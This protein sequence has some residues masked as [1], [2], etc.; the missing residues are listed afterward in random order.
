MK[1]HGANMIKPAFIAILVF[2]WLSLSV[3]QAQTL[4]KEYVYNGSKLIATESPVPHVDSLS[5]TASSGFSTVVTVNLSDH[6]SFSNLAVVN[7]LINNYLNGNYA[8]Y[9][10]VV[11]SV[12]NWIAYLVND[13][14]TGYSSITI[15]GT[16]NTNNSQCTL[17]ASQSSVVGSGTQLTVKLA[18]TFSSGFVGGKVVYAAV[19]NVGGINSGWQP[20]GTFFVGTPPFNVSPQS[21][22]GSSGIFT[23]TFAKNGYFSDHTVVANILLNSALDGANACYM[24]FLFDQGGRTLILVNDPGNG[25]QPG[26]VGFPPGGGIGSNN[27]TQ[28]AANSQCSIDAS[29]S[30]YSLI[31]SSGNSVM[32]LTLK[33]NFFGAAFRGDRIFYTAIQESGGSSGWQAAGAWVVQ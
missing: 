21:G 16:G 2:G 29:N 33:L 12:T 6:A 17:N 5:E 24:A 9:V 28:V 4:V 23:F 22:T 14:G 25:Y 11:P 1:S 30:S 13:L 32:T 3:G 27:S 10:A 31:E 7:I 26:S 20:A 15:P 19:G 8:C 18:I